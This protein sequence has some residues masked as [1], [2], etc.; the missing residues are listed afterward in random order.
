V[1]NAGIQIVNPVENY[2]CSDWRKMQ[3]IYV[4]GAFLTT[5]ASLKYIYERNQGGVA[6]YM[7]SVYSHEASPLK[8]AYV[9]ASQSLLGHIRRITVNTT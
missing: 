9:T 1:S 7:C 4:D 2:S 6:I 8:S 3:A 5:K